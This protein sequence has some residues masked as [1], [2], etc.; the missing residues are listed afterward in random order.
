MADG[1]S[2]WSMADGRWPMAD[3][4]WP[5]AD[6]RWPMVSREMDPPC[7]DAAVRFRE[8]DEGVGALIV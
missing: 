7:H 8:H 2:R 3:G 6:G 5:M 4:R 1:R